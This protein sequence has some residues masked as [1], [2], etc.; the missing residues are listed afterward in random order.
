MSC[1]N[2]ELDLCDPPESDTTSGAVRGQSLST[3]AFLLAGVL[4][5]SSD[6]FPASA[7][8]L[9][10]LALSP[11]MAEAASASPAPATTCGSVK[12]VYKEHQCCGLPTKSLPFQVVPNPKKKL[13]LSSN[14]CAGKK[15][16]AGVMTT[17]LNF[18]NIACFV[19]GTLNAL[20]QAGAD[21]TKGRAQTLNAGTRTPTTDPYWKKGLC[22]VNVHWHLGAEHRSKGEYDESGKGAGIAGTPYHLDPNARRTAKATS[23][24]RYGF[25]CHHYDANNLKFTTEYKWQH[26]VGMHVGETYEVHWP[27]SAIGACHT[28]WQYQEPFYDGVFCGWTQGVSNLVQSDA[29]NLVNA[30]GVQAQVFTIVNDEDYYF[31]DLMRGAIV[32][33]D[34]WK[35]VAAYTG[36]T[37]G[38][39][40]DNGV[41]SKY[42]PITW[43]VDRKCHLIS[44]STFDKMC[45]DM[46]QQPDDMSGDLYPHGSRITVLA[47]LTA[48]NMAEAGT[49]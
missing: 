44:A 4:G 11:L 37:T 9:S 36:S 6:T 17:G 7:F 18:D 47:N 3:M 34:F 16:A 41:C 49:R 40:R 10:S 21:V 15:P 13:T 22:P 31:P 33:G 25:A 1:W 32:D 28:P 35:D 8:L 19:N 12:S 5:G 26:C 45:A 38:T 14:P 24:E 27:H 46:M 42:T 43:Q 23:K 39:S 2:E 30:V 20:E 29:Q 48:D